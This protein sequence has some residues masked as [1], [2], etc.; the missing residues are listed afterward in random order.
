MLHKY[1]SIRNI[2]RMNFK[3]FPEFYLIWQRYFIPGKS[4]EKLAH[5]PE[6]GCQQIERKMRFFCLFLHYKKHVSEK[7]ILAY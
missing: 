5:R 4:R 1:I 3:T 7:C 6:R 2:F